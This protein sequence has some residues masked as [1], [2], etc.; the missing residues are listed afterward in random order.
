MGLLLAMHSL[1]D[2][3]EKQEL[4]KV[5]V[6][7]SFIKKAVMYAAAPLLTLYYSF[8]SQFMRSKEANGLISRV[9]GKQSILKNGCI[10]TT[11]P[12]EKL[13]K[14]AKTHKASIN[15]VVMTVISNVMKEFLVEIGDT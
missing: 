5:L 8:E 2:E 15:D 3:P 12:L 14:V 7:M 13:K 4:P 1:T 6:S 10:G 11:I 9:D